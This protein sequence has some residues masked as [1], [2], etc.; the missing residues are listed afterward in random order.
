MQLDPEIFAVGIADI[1]ERAIVP[2]RDRI[3]ALE[4]RLTAL[5]S[6]AAVDYRGVFSEGEKYKRGD[7]VT[8]SNAAFAA[9]AQRTG[10]LEARLAAALARI[11]QLEARTQMKYEGVHKAGLEYAAGA[12]VTHGGSL[13]IAKETTVD[14]PGASPAWQLAV[15]RGKE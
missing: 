11:D 15:K 6:R 14:L 4:P 10:E 9:A 12:C 13:W 3:A 8:D 2:L 5:E 1:L 7:L